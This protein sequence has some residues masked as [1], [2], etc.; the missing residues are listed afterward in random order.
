M[1]TKYSLFVLYNVVSSFPSVRLVG[2]ISQPTLPSS[3]SSYENQRT[4]D[5]QLITYDL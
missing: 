4:S 5:C 1:I 3:K 2:T